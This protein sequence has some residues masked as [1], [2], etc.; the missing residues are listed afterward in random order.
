MFHY[1]SKILEL[2][3]TK[4][5]TSLVTNMAHMF[6]F[7]TIKNFDVRNFN[8]K[9]VQNMEGMFQLCTNV[10]SYDLSSFDTT[11]VENMKE[12]FIII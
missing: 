7:I 10:E 11:N 3:V 12:M 9:N 8:T 2:N 1:A 4:F 6:S 5:D